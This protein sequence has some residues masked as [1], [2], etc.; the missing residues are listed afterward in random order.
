MTKIETTSVDFV[1]YLR[2]L[3]V[4]EHHKTTEEA[5]ALT[6]KYPNVIVNGIMLGLTFQSL[7]ITAQ[8]IEIC[9]SEERERTRKDAT[10][11]P[12]PPTE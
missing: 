12:T 6:K 4:E 8:A 10:T 3:L 1:N 11:A 7:R 5:E 9:E 2:K